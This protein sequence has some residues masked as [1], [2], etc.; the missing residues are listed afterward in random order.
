MNSHNILKDLKIL[1]AGAVVSAGSSINNLG[2]AIDMSGFDGCL[3][4]VPIN[5]SVATGVATASAEQCDTSG[6]S[7]AALVGD[8][9]AK[10]CTVDDDLN[11]KFLIVD[12]F[13]PSKQYLKLRRKSATAN[14]A[15][16]AATAILYNARARPTDLGDVLTRVG[17]VTPAEG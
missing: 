4:I 14:I 6:G 3:F 7:Y 2:N 11:G 15:Y 9:A 8:D 13:K 16:E 17:V 10:T 1:L 5:D 12:V